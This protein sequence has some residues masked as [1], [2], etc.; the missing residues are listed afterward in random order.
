MPSTFRR[1]CRVSPMCSVLMTGAAAGLI[2]CAASTARSQDAPPASPPAAPATDAPPSKDARD[3]WA[4]AVEPPNGHK[5]DFVIELSRAGEAADWSGSISIPAQNYK[6]PLTITTIA[7]DRMVFTAPLA[8]APEAAWPAFDLTIDET[9]NAARGTMKQ[10]GFTMKASLDRKKPGDVA[11]LGPPRPQHPAPPYPYTVRDVTF[12][13]PRG[14]HTLAGTLTIPSTPGRHP[15]VVLL[16]GSGPQDRDATLFAHKPFLVIADRLTREGMVVLRVDDRGVGASTLPEGVDGGAVTSDDLASDA[17][18][19]FSFLSTQPEVDARRAGLM[20]H[21]EGGLLAMLAA[22]EISPAFVVL[23]AGPGLRG[24]EL[25]K[26]QN[27]ALLEAAGVNGAALDAMVDAQARAMD[28]LL[29][30]GT[31]QELEAAVR[32]TAAAQRQL[33]GLDPDSP[34]GQAMLQAQ[35]AMAD[36]AWF[37]RFVALDPAPLIEALKMPVL[38]L[39]GSLDRQVTPAENL[40]AIRAALERGGNQDITVRELPGLNHLFQTCRTGAPG[41]YGSIE[42]TFAPA[43]LDAIVEWL[44]PRFIRPA[45]AP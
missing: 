7:T 13:N 4:G 42:E 29:R 34:Q 25:M 41:E 3:V 26:L 2:F 8:G 1:L 45:E 31:R 18:A 36:S 44:T 27:R 19:A 32:E 9:G 6:G 20:G 33:T 24:A 10:S 43:A 12:T 30:G 37:R 28:I 5:L 39:N 38:A 16:T 21:S 11:A 22:R 35:L 17:R 15:A 40:A 23:L 14:K